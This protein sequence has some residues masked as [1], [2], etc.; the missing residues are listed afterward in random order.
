VGPRLLKKIMRAYRR[1]PDI[2]SSLI[3]KCFDKDVRHLNLTEGSI[4]AVVTSP[5]YM[6]ALDYVRD[7]RLRLW[8]LGYEKETAFDKDSPSNPQEFERLISEFFLM[9]DKVLRPEKKII[10]VTGEVN[11]NGRIVDTASLILDTAKET[12]NFDH[13][14]TIKDNIPINR[15]IRRKNR[16]TRREWIIVL[17][18]RC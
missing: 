9:I 3:R 2:D 14:M 16:C 5:P 18:K 8:F 13:L 17:R 6:N 7:N 1:F 11:K 12:G 15:R 4:D 10:I